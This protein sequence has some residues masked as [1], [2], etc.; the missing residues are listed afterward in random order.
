MSP[1]HFPFMA[2]SVTTAK[3]GLP[4]FTLRKQEWLKFN[5]YV[6]LYTHISNPLRLVYAVRATRSCTWLWPYMIKCGNGWLLLWLESTDQERWRVKSCCISGLFPLVM[7]LL[8]WTLFR[9]HLHRLGFL[10]YP[11]LCQGKFITEVFFHSCITLRKIL[12]AVVWLI[13]QRAVVQL[14][15]ILSCWKRCTKK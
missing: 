11:S 4:Y 3:F 13:L 8:S 10:S 14:C 2:L 6:S 9:T 5:F 1:C 12:S 7:F 15:L